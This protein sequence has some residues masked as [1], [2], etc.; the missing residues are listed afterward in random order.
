VR[1]F[2]AIPLD[3][4]VKDKLVALQQRMKKSGAKLKLVERENLH[5]TV[6]FIGEGDPKEWVR[7][8]DQIREKPFVVMFDRLGAFPSRGHARVLWAGCGPVE[9]LLNIHRLIGEGE[10]VPHV[11]L[12]RVKSRSDDTLREMLEEGINLRVDVKK[13]LLM[14]STLTPRGPVYEV[15]H[16]KSL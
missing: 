15:V 2:V 9:S 7:K 12:A 4:N 16:E 8:I 1:L 13:V 6:R 14:N 11:T 10:L 3:D 5:M